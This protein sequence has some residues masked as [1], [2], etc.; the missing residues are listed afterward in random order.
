MS[1]S[2]WQ[3][4]TQAQ[5]AV[6]ENVTELTDTTSPAPRPR[7]LMELENVTKT[8]GA[9]T[10][11]RGVS[12]TV[13]EGEI[14]T[15]LGPSGSG[16]STI[17]KIIAGFVDLTSG[18]IRI[19]GRDISEL[20]AADRGI[21]MV[22][23][24]YALF[25]HMTV[26]ENVAYG[27]RMRKVPKRER[28]LKAQE[29]LELVHL[30]G[31]GERLPRELSGGQQQRVALARA[32]AFDPSLLLMDEPLGALDRELRERMVE[33]IRR[34]HDEIGV[35]ILYVT[36]DRE[37]A[38]TLSDRIGIMRLGVL[39]GL[40]TPAALLNAPSS[41]FLASFFGGHSLLPAQIVEPND[42]SGFV[43]LACLGQAIRVACDEPGLDR[44]A[45]VSVVVSARA[46]N[47]ADLP[48]GPSLVIDV[49]VRDVIDLGD[50]T[51][52]TC[53]VMIPGDE[54]RAVSVNG[55]RLGDRLGSFTPGCAAQL[56]ADP[57]LLHVVSR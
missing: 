24:H 32:L 14:L 37:E 57:R 49:V 15:L 41:G 19:R 26:E 53:D 27:L 54:A 16:K 39:E 44:D 4:Q 25:P 35:T 18:R 22:F 17:L 29:M 42:G 23:Q 48:D 34:V 5:T 1:S 6:L 33:E 51:R 43:T 46:L 2:S 11:I 3:P 56:Y 12:L 10:A 30:G 9:T 52:I 55:D 20:S 28:R 38:L 50:R 7:A 13:E 8:Y 21:G 40:G 36:H 45:A 31:T 47:G